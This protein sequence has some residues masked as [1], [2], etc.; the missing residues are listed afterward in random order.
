VIAD[1][2]I[3]SLT[4]HLSQANSLLDLARRLGIECLECGGVMGDALEDP[5]AH[6]EFERLEDAVAATDPA[7]WQPREEGGSLAH[8]L[9]HGD[10]GE[11]VELVET[12]TPL[13][14]LAVLRGLCA[15]P[16]REF[17]EAIKGSVTL[18][19]GMPV[20]LADRPL[21][22][23]PRDADAE[24]DE[25]AQAEE[26]DGTPYFRTLNMGH[27][28]A[29]LPY[30]LFNLSAGGQIKVE[31]DFKHREQIDKLTWSD[32][33]GLPK[34]ATL[35]PVVDRS[36]HGIELVGESQ[37][38][39]VRPKHWDL[40]DALD[41]L[42]RVAAAGVEIAVLPELC[43]PC[44]GALEEKLAENPDQFPALVVAGSAHVREPHRSG[45]REIRANESRV[46]L[47]GERIATHRKFHHFEFREMGDF[48]FDRKRKEALTGEQKT[49][50]VL[51]SER[52]RL[53]VLICADLNDNR[54]PEI[55]TSTGINMLLVP[56]LTPRPGSFNGAICNVA[57][58]CQGIATIV[59]VELNGLE[60]HGAGPFFAMAA[61]PRPA[62]HSQSEEFRPD[63]EALRPAIGVI[64]FNRPLADAMAWMR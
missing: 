37:F 17:F 57:S 49:V 19:R 48:A 26:E 60:G 35:H 62:A 21:P 32:E 43:L 22:H 42:R 33:H 56:S 2:T 10:L 9:E 23:P 25:I 5:D 28:I 18:D 4:T 12:N 51:A 24:L 47:E 55:L 36:T 64:D 45:N 46:Y 27:S 34:I 1:M 7:L 50:T 38:F 40:D 41:Q 20:L 3:V 16:L 63:S 54:V 44:P 52:T 15:R 61:A 14:H 30:R 6:E 8:V 59:N 39:D 29:E 53:A 58:Y 11:L 13:E 31:L